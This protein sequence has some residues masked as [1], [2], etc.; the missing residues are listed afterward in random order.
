MRVA[1]HLTI[2]TGKKE[3]LADMVGRVRQAFWDAGL[4]EPAI[5]FTFVDSALKKGA[6]IDRV[7]KRYPEMERFLVF[8]PILPG[9]S[10]SRTLSNSTTGDP[11]DYA[12][13]L[14]IAGGVPRTYALSA[15]WFHFHTPVFGERLIGLP[16]MGHSLP[17]VIIT[18]NRGVTGRHCALW[19][20]TTADVEIEDKELPPNPEAIDRVVGAL[21]KIKSSTQVP[22]LAP[23]GGI[24]GAIPP[25]NAEAVK[26]IVADYRARIKELVERAGMPHH[27]PPAAEI[28]KD[29]AMA[30]PRKPALAAA[31]KPMGYACRGGSGE[32]H[33]TRRTSGNLT[34]EL[35]L[36]CGTWSHDVSAMFHIA[37]AGFK[38]SLGIPVAPDAYGQYP[39]GDATQW[40]KIVEN[41]AAMVLELERSFVPEVEKAAGFSPAWYRP[42]S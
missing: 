23:G 36:D 42:P 32:L 11:A 27:L 19:V 16:K 24:V 15:S 3:P 10:N 12:T 31:L 21:G 37:G 18:D 5:R 28:Q 13:I 7:L 1:T 17:G 35:H 33:A 30:G 25:A 29:V 14:A 41:L 4:G 22:I 2:D 39:I 20:Y 40:Q 34:V 26:G 8:R 6:P 9:S 38:A